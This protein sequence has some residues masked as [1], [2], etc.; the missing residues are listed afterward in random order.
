MSMY[1]NLSEQEILQR[2]PNGIVHCEGCKTMVN[3]KSIP[4]DWSAMR[5][6]NL[7]LVGY[8]CGPCI[9]E[10]EKND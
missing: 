1:K 10:M 3:M 2:F 4:E 5:N 9:L 6:A 8:I 7:Q